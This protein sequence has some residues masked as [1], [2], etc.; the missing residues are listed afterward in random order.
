MDICAKRAGKARLEVLQHYLPPKEEAPSE[1]L[2]RGL[3]G[4]GVHRC[5]GRVGSPRRETLKVILLLSYLRRRTAYPRTAPPTSRAAAGAATALNPMDG[6]PLEGSGAVPSIFV[7]TSCI[8]PC[9][10]S[11][12]CCPACCRFSWASCSA[13]CPS[14][15]CMYCCAACTLSCARSRAACTLSCACSRA[16]CS[17]SSRLARASSSAACPSGV[18]IYCCASCTLSCACCNLSCTCCAFS[19]CAA[20]EG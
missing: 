2:R 3:S 20:T 16:A 17:A 13:C 18:C 12:T 4:G 1:V 7:V 15:D 19:P 11:C 5:A 6:P 14:G 10:A 8:F 9:A